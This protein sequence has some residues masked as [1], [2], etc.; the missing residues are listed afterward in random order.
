MNREQDKQNLH[1]ISWQNDLT[2]SV[3]DSLTSEGDDEKCFVFRTSL[4]NRE[5]V[6]YISGILN[7]LQ[8]VIKW[9]VDLQDWENVL[10]IECKSITAATIIRILSEAGVS[11][12]E[13]PL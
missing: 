5:D 1:H 6:E 10:R 12:E 3:I 7:N 11:A 13:L 4:K 2:E 9:S 8:G